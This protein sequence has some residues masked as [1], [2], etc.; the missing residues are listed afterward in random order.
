[1]KN[2]NETKRGFLLHAFGNKDLD[3]GKIAVCCALSIK[4][5]LKNNS[6]TVIMNEGTEKWTRSTVP[7]NII[8]KAFD[9]I[10]I[11]KDTFHVG[12]RR[13]FDSPWINFKAEFNNQP[14]V[15]SY[16]Y[17]PYDETILLDTD[18]IVM[19]DNFDHVWGST[20][21]VLMN[22]DVIDLKSEKFDIVDQR[23][24]KHGIPMYWATAVYF[25]KS[26]FSKAFFDLV[27][28]VKDEYNFFQ[29]LYG[30][31]PGFYRND[32]SFSV[33]AHIIGGYK[34]GI[35]SFPESK[36]ITSYQKD[37][38]VDV[39]DSNEILFLSNN[40][41]EPWLD[42]LVNIKEMNVHIM[43]KRELLRVSDKFIECC[44][45]KL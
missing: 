37:G 9:K 22:K 18:Y 14:R 40:V 39:I 12:K 38:I 7:E 28:Y 3:Y 16:K 15:L 8:E 36:I 24:S 26:E 43:N 41:D 13:H 2:K 10:I 23:L 42:T 25:R 21:D 20:E 27:E 5:N 31:K 11:S 6:V 34:S 30:F 35:K 45:E 4:T 19:N 33:A 29:F 44:M 17:S 1:M 32:F